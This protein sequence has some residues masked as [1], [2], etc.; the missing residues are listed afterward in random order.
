[1]DLSTLSPF[2][3]AIPLYYA[4]SNSTPTKPVAEFEFLRYGVRYSSTLPR[5][6]IARDVLLDD[7]EKPL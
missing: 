1:M 3:L 5:L 7:V 2:M 6:P 4:A